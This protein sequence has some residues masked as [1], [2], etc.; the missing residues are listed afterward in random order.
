[1]RLDHWLGDLIGE[2]AHASSLAGCQDY[3][4]HPRNDP[5]LPPNRKKFLRKNYAA[6][7]SASADWNEFATVRYKERNSADR[8]VLL[9]SRK[10]FAPRE[11]RRCGEVCDKSCGL[12]PTARDQQ[13]RDAQT[14]QQ[15]C[16]GLRHY[17]VSGE[18]RLQERGVSLVW[19][20][21]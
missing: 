15:N 3:R 13:S 20:N 2:P 14:C 5:H 1:M 16:G 18:R 17:G 10:T 7:K 4:F 19:G 8:G 21:D 12:P 11:K 9:L 6:A